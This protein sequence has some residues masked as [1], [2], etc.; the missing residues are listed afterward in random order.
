M[1]DVFAFFIVA[2]VLTVVAG[3]V[4]VW[5]VRR[6]IRRSFERSTERALN[7]LA[8]DTCD[9]LAGGGRSDSRAVRRYEAV[10]DEAARAKGVTDLGKVAAKAEVRRYV[11]RAD[12]G[13][14]TARRRLS[15]GRPSAAVA[16][17]PRSEDPGR[18]SARR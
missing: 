9:D 5:D 6:R 1:L 15:S 8:A 18:R 17:R 3:S 11:S 12:A 4:V 14:R 13:L 16:R 7:D 2:T 10:R